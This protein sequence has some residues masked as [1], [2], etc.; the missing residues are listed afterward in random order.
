MSITVEP[1]EMGY[2]YI[3]CG[4]GTSGV[5][6]AARLA[7]DPSNSVLVIEAGENNSL[8]ENTIMVVVDEPSPGAN[9]RQVKVSRGKFLGGSSGVN[10]TLCIRGTPQD[11]DDW[12]MPGWSGEEAPISNMILESMEDQGLPLHPDMFST[13][14]TSNGCG[15]APRSV[16]KGDRTTSANYLANKGLNLAIKTNTTVDKV[17]LD[18]Q[19]FSHDPRATAVEVIEKDGTE[20]EIRARK[21]IIISGGAYCSPIILMRSGIGPKSELESH[22]IDCQVDLPG[23]GKNLMDHLIVFIFYETTKPKITKDYL[24]YRPNSLVEAYRQWKEEKR[25]P[26]STFPFGVFAY[27]RLDKRLASEPAWVSAPRQPGR[28]PMGLTKSQ[29]NIELFTTECYVGPKQYNQFPD[30]EKIS[31][32]LHYC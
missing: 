1:Q 16:Y 10:G 19:V 12:E 21:E 26:L 9:N 18:N 4:G 27:S 28:D 24:L 6:V 30:G 31:C 15:H 17:I 2:D 23:V 13:G 7:E 8:L 32:I 22:G 20:K 25:G 3:V 11:Y 14:E 5:V 29:P